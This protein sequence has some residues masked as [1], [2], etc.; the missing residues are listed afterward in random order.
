MITINHRHRPVQ[1]T[2]MTVEEFCTLLL[3]KCPK[4][5][6]VFLTYEGVITSITEEVIYADSSTFTQP[7]VMLNAER[8]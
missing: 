4:D 6:P 7:V 3:T 1:E 2:T 8:Y 5:T